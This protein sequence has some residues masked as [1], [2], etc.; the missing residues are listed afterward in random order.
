MKYFIFLFLFSINFTYSQTNEVYIFNKSSLINIYDFNTVPNITSTTEIAQKGW[1]FYIDQKVS[2]GYVIT[3]LKWTKN[4]SR[5]NNFYASE[6]SQVVAGKTIKKE[7]KVY[8]YISDVDYSDATEKYINESPKFSFVTGAITI[9]IKIRP[10][11][12]EVNADGSKVRPFDFTGEVNVGLSIGWR[13]RLHKNRRA[14]LIPS[15]G[16]NLT[17]IS[18]DPITVRNDIIKS[19]TNV[20]SITPFIGIIGEYDSFQLSLLTGWDRLSGK[21]GENWV[22]QGKPWLGV[23]IGYNIFNTKGSEPNN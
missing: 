19:K 4:D 6:T 5:N 17:S 21:V 8:F 22:Y 20:S 10:S 13:I 18:V 12:D 15:A 1:K 7:S 9:P 2:T 3:F 14:F 11:G 23:G 16:L